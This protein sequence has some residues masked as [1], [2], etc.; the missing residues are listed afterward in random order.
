MEKLLDLYSDY[1]LCSTSQTTST[2]LSV[3][4]EGNLSHDQVTRFLSNNIFESK[5]LW[6]EVKPLLREYEK[7]DGYLIFDDTIIEKQYMD[8][9]DLICWHWDHSKS[10]HIKGINLLSAYY[11]SS[12]SEDEDFHLPLSYE[13][14]T[15]PIHYKDTK[16]G[17]DK[18]KSEISKNELM[19]KMLSQQIKNQVLFKYVL[20]DSWFCSNDNMR[21][22][23][24]RKKYFIFEVKNNRLITLSELSRNQGQWQNI[25]QVELPEN[26]P[27]KV[28]LKDL[29][30]P[31]VLIKQVFINKDLST[32]VRF[33]VSNDYT[34]SYGQFTTIY[35]KRWAVEEYHKS[36]KQNASIASSPARMVRTQAN[37]IFAAMVACV[38]LEKIRVAKRMNHFAIK[39]NLYI[40]AVKSA[41]TEL[42][43]IKLKYNI[44]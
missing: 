34:L 38:K 11:V 4:S 41:L 13:L 19:Q 26:T 8:E 2:G 44:A 25:S 15:K 18:C 12:L 28:W 7:S 36:I 30:F 29:E 37:H 32:G 20:A 23:A 35:K 39:A 6:K 10:R 33:L 3:L 42:R 43:D 5:S 31:V 27:V 16:T 9:N 22:I 14:I 1:L 24:K 21:F 17:K 40:K